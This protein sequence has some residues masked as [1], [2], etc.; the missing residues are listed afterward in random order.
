MNETS[1]APL[2]PDELSPSSGGR[3]LAGYF[4]QL[5]VS[6]LTALDLVLAKKVAIEIVLEPA[7]DED[8]EADVEHGPGALS[9]KVVLDNYRLVIQCKLRNTGPWK[10]E[11][12]SR[13]LAHGKKR[14][15]ARDRLADP[16]IR[17]LLVT[18][19]DLDG[20]TRQLKVE[21]VGVW[22]PASE[23]PPDMARNLP[24]GAGGRV[25]ILGTMDQEKINARTE[26]LLSQRFRVPHSNLQSCREA[27]RSEA[28]SRMR[29]AGQGVWTRLDVERLITAAG[30]YVGESADLE[31]FVPPTNWD[32]FKT[33]IETKHAVVIT[34][35]SGTGKTRT[36]KALTAY[37]RD[38]IPG[39]KHVTVQGGPEKIADD[40]ASRPVLYEI[41]D[42]WGRFRLEPA[43]VPWNGAI[44]EILQSAGPDRKFVVTS[45]SDVLHESKLRLKDKWVVTLE[46][47]NYGPAERAKLFENRLPSLPASLQPVVL[48]SRNDAIERL[49]TPLEMHRYFAVLA[50]GFEKDEN[51]GQYIA[52][53]LSDA[54]Q[55]SI[56][57]AL[58][59]NIRQRGTWA[60]AAI[61][62]GL[63]K[64]GA[65][66]TF[67]VLPSIQAG[68]TKRWS[69]LED[70]LEP[71]LNFL[72]AGRNLRQVEATL[73]YQHPRVELGLEEALKEKPGQSARVLS[74]LIEVLI[75]LDKGTGS[76]WG[77]E[78]AARLVH[79]VRERSI[80]QLDL[81]AE[82][83]SQ[84]DAWINER[85]AGTGPDFREDLK[86]AASVGSA[87]SIPAE[88][89][90]WLTHQ[91]RDKEYWFFDKWSAPDRSPDWFQKVAADHRTRVLCTAFITRELP[92]HNPSYPTR[93]AGQVAELCADLT[94]AFMEA[95]LSI[96]RDG[97][98]P[99]TSVIAE[100]ALA[101]LNGFEEVVAQAVAYRDELSGKPDE[102]FKLRLA[103][104]EYDGDYGSHY[105]ESISEDGQTAFEFLEC[106]VTMRRERNGWRAIRDHAHVLDMLYHWIRTA[107][108]G[109][110]VTIE[111]WS[112][113]ARA[114][115]DRPEE[116]DFWQAMQK[117][118]PK[119]V[120]STLRERIVAGGVIREVRLKAVETALF[121][122]PTEFFSAVG[123]VVRSNHTRRALELALEFAAV[124]ETNAKKSRVDF[125]TI[126]LQFLAALPP[127]LAEAANAVLAFS[128]EALSKDAL[129]L[130]EGLDTQGNVELKSVQAEALSRVGF[131]LDHL[132][133]EILDW[134]DNDDETI[135][136]AANAVRVAARCGMWP[137]VE[138]AL[139][140]RF[141]DVRQAA[142]LSLARRSP[143]PLD[144]ELR[145]SAGDKGHRV[146]ETVLSLLQERPSAD[147]MDA[148][149]QLAADTW[150]PQ[151]PRHE[152]ERNFPIAYAAAHLL[153]EPPQIEDRYVSDIGKILFQTDDRDVKLMLLRALV[154][155][156]SGDAR[157]R[158]VKL[159]LK[160]G[161]PPH[162]RLAAE[163][164]CLEQQSVDTELAAEIPHK[165]LLFRTA[166]VAL[167]LTLV[168]AACAGHCQVLDAARSLAAKP[169]RRALLIPLAIKA[170]ARDPALA[171]AIVE[172]L[173]AATASAL[174]NTLSGSGKLSLEDLDGLGDVRTLQVVKPWLSAV[175]KGPE[176]S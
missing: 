74:Y 133:K 3:S 69:D 126:R 106:Y 61:T 72:I 41:E 90:R 87:D 153:S 103:N 119:E 137:I 66:Q 165:Q 155:N 105:Y 172:L 58:I 89:S 99:N 117:S 6:V 170:N 15:S 101:D 43:S 132:L 176:A 9:E 36:A 68:L 147:N 93:F 1:S 95:A 62:W 20:V 81:P 108:R 12:L 114:A 118:I 70:G 80:V 82:R 146:R 174:S 83:Q 131:E 163:A 142:L 167:A 7:T 128:F 52:R 120:L 59:H 130:F 54:H 8:L 149:L 40:P 94:P 140:H 23:L 135:G 34:G 31:G 67:K 158:V 84:L 32:D 122:A 86:L 109:T 14:K 148:I 150:E 30:G 2:G 17:Y 129:L 151:Q 77:T 115:F 157:K 73:T 44:A 97:Y 111:E 18:S 71:Y 138:A 107:E 102:D 45:R 123:T 85:L 48:N 88:L 22:P 39:I 112:A 37:L 136:M 173:P 78:G 29:G 42:P 13:L 35:A 127:A 166:P 159:A 169:D 96:V 75:D 53:C 51:P 156:G 21:E 64:S 134:P 19:A 161:N 33:A 79:A 110:D 25:A 47:E 145:K 144:L 50:D 162:H 124:R 60:W 4:Y 49:A 160:S 175:M 56:E 152:E 24:A 63:F 91:N 26:R 92:H 100:G 104:G 65:R 38:R 27:L 171:Q 76:D 141:A 121:A 143:G 11:D 116:R 16:S 28:L 5:D 46:D 98:N 139:S 125:E 57:A 154:R 168:V 113:I 164:L 10:H 55:T